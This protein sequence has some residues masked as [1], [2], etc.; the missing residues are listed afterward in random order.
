MVLMSYF[1]CIDLG[2]RLLSS[3]IF[4][5]S[6]HKFLYGSGASVDHLIKGNAPYAFLDFQI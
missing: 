6:A 3:C 2:T 5:L 4:I 1:H